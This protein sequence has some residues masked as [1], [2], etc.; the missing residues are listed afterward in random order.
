VRLRRRWLPLAP[1]PLDRPSWRALLWT[2]A[3]TGD[4]LA[5]GG[6]A[7]LAITPVLAWH[8]GTANPWGALAT[9]VATPPT[10]VALWLGLPL[11]ACDGL[12]PGGPWAGLY[13]GLDASLAAL[14]AIAEW[15]AQL[16][17]ATLASGAPSPLL[18]CAW[19]LL[20]LPLG[21]RLDLALRALAVGGLLLCW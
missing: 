1:W 5:I 17:G 4:G 12:W 15:A 19:P 18:L 9:L 21:D 8:F 20:F 16:P 14:A 11:M 10:A 2:A 6:A 13:A 3:A 7:S